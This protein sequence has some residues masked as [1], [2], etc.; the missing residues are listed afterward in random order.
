MVTMA[1]VSFFS[2]Q[3]LHSQPWCEGCTQTTAG[4]LLLHSILCIPYSTYY[5]DSQNVFY[6]HSG[7][8]RIRN[9]SWRVEFAA[10]KDVRNQEGKDKLM[11]EEPGCQRL[12]KESWQKEGVVT[13]GAPFPSCE[14]AL[15]ALWARATVLAEAG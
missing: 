9:V 14:S 8:L 12:G 11:E 13:L 1:T 7:M 10:C 3:F 5:F 15:V 4:V 6:L 2:V